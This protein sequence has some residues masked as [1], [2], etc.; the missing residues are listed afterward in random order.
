MMVAVALL[1][2]ALASAAEQR[3][4]LALIAAGACA[5][6]AVTGLLIF[7]STAH[8]DRVHHHETPHLLSESYFPVPAWAR[9][10]RARR[11]ARERGR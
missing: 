5:A 1:A 10:A 3:S 6:V 2:M 8:T 9:R 11:L 7:E 4:A